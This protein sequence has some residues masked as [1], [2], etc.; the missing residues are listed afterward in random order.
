VAVTVLADDGVA[1]FT[2]RRVAEGAATSVPAIYELFGDKGGLVRE[3]YFE[4]FRRLGARCLTLAATD[5][6][7]D[8]LLV[9]IA[10]FRAFV[11]ENPVLAQVM[12]SRPF[13]DFHPG[14]DDMRATGAVREFFVGR[15]DR[16]IQAGMIAGDATDIAHV[17]LA[18]AQGLSTQESAGWLG[19]SRASM[20]RRWALA[21]EAALA[22][23]SPDVSGPTG[24]GT[25]TPP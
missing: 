11:R 1:A 19:S 21:Y 2:A 15:V 20:N 9:L 18:L 22:G 14:P 25:S 24:P 8:D 12:F 13:T 6:P 23:L 17:L 4:G 5:D 16:C 10:V 7:R 3:V